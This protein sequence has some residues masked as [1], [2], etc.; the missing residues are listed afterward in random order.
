MNDAKQ[1][2]PAA[3]LERQICSATEP[4]NEREWWAHR[5][6]ERL[7]DRLSVETL[8]LVETLARAEKAEAERDALRA[9]LDWYGEKAKEM[10]KAALHSD[11]K[12]MLS[13]M[14]ELAVDYGKRAALGER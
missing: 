1:A 3:E 12:R 6:I 10:G 11:S 2:T 14:H 7:R 13:L 8:A 4:K 9:A 5:E